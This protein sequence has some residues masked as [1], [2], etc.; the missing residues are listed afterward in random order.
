MNLPTEDREQIQLPSGQSTVYDA[1]GVGNQQYNGYAAVSPPS[2]SLPPVSGQQ[3]VHTLR[4]AL[5]LLGIICLGTLG[6]IPLAA[7]FLPASFVSPTTI[8]KLSAARPTPMPTQAP[9][10]PGG[11]CT[12]TPQ[13]MK[14]LSSGQMTSSTPPP[15]WFTTGHT[16][17]DLA[18]AQACAASFVTTY[19]TIDANDF[20]TLEA[21]TSMLSAGAK[22][23]FYGRLQ[24]TNADVRM[25]PSWRAIIQK[26]NLK[27]TAQ[28]QLPRLL[29]VRSVNN[30]FFAWMLVTC[31]LSLMR[32]DQTL[33]RDV[34]LTV[35]LV[36]VASQSNDAGTGWQVS[37]WQ[38][39]DTPFA[40]PN[41]V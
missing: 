40:V 22:S 21:S 23:R 39:G 20:R 14:Y 32:S 18:K 15:M 25:D 2:P 38:E 5:L 35:L 7:H 11:E 31:S 3:T 12:A 13:Q 33:S 24:S 6:A 19:E 34:Q 29:E 8:S 9:V 28:V 16:E 4:I 30:R 17:T 27:Q 1:Y 36:N 41:P 26:Q 37:G 10:L